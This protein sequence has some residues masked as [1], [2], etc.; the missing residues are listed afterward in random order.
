MRVQVVVDYATT[1]FSNFVIKYLH[2]NEQVRETVFACSYLA[3][4]K[5]FK[6]K[7]DQKSRDTGPLI[8]STLLNIIIIISQFDYIL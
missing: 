8:Q 6:Q 5:S 4:V 7:N 2:E 1:G 3:R